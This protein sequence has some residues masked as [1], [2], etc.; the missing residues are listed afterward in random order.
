MKGNQTVKAKG[1]RL[2]GL[3][4]NTEVEGTEGV[5][6]VLSSAAKVSFGK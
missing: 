2:R 1:W 4:G 5:T 3:A 6:G